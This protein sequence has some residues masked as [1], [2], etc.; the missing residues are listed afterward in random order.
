M[1]SRHSKIKESQ[2]LDLIKYLYISLTKGDNLLLNF[3]W[4]KHI[5]I[6]KTKLC[7]VSLGAVTS[8]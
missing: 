5:I 4:M 6:N 3:V 8:Y 1:Y 7:N 2:F